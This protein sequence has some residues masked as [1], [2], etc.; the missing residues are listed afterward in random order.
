MEDLLALIKYLETLS[1]TDDQGFR[2]ALNRSISLLELTETELAREF[3]VS[4]S[5]IG[6]WLSGKS[7]PHPAG[8][9]PVFE[10]LS[11]LAR[12]KVLLELAKV[13]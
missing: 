12:E 9:K 4:I 11:D 2:T 8:R 6:R 1:T 10:Y 7:S 5:T 13:E 3:G